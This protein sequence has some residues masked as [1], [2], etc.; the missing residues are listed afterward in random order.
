MRI[1]LPV[2]FVKKASLG[3]YNGGLEL[4]ITDYETKHMIFYS[5]DNIEPLDEDM[6]MISSG[7]LAYRIALSMKEVDEKIMHQR[8]IM[9]Y[10][11]GN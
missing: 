8:R 1:P 6:C 11:G 5:I 10:G 9:Y 2:M 4:K 3:K 7:E